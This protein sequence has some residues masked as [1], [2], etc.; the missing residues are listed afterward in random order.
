MSDD[1]NDTQA[2]LDLL[3]TETYQNAAN[4]AD[5]SGG[6]GGLPDPGVYNLLVVGHGQGVKD[7]DWGPAPWKSI[8]FRVLD[9]GAFADGEFRYFMN[10]APSKEGK[11]R[12]GMKDLIAFGTTIGLNETRDLPILNA[13]VE[14][15]VT[16]G[17]VVVRAKVYE[18][19]GR[20]YIE[21]QSAEMECPA[22]QELAAVGT[23][24]FTNADAAEANTQA[25][26]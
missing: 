4:D 7:L 2:F 20:R 17:D 8:D 9:P 13:I 12:R 21:F 26:A 5:V 15:A 22:A 6:G 16:Q 1:N 25:F 18:Y 24:A 10:L 14:A 19:R 23:S 11:A 3:T